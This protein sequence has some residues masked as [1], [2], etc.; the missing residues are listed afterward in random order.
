MSKNLFN[1]ME[2]GNTLEKVK[3]D[4]KIYELLE[5]F[6]QLSEEEKN[7]I[8]EKATAMCQ[9]NEKTQRSHEITE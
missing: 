5:C 2:S 9:E 8:L 7:A 1:V 3:S 6:C 4:E